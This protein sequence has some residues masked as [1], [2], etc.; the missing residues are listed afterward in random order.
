VAVA[1]V[2]EPVVEMVVATAATD[3][4]GSTALIMLVAVQVD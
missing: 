1:A 4:N 2:Q 3:C